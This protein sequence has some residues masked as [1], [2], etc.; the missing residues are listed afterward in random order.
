MSKKELSYKSA[1][2][3]LES[4]VAKL[5]EEEIDVDKLAVMIN[6]ASELI[7]FCKN[8]LIKS[9]EEVDKALKMFEKNDEN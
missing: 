5:E 3:E 7:K 4:I 1:M 9:Q 8:R 2:Q 6:R